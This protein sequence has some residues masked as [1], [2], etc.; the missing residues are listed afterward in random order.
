[1]KTVLILLLSLCLANP[2]SAQEPVSIAKIT[3]HE[4]ADKSTKTSRPFVFQGYSREYDLSRITNE[5]SGN[6][7]LGESIAK[8]V[9]LLDDLYTSEVA[10]VPGN[11]QMKTIIKKPVIYT[12]V[13][14]IEKYMAKAVKKGEISK[15]LAIEEFNRVLDVA[16]SVLSEDTRQFEVEIEALH[17]DSAR[18]DLFTRRV[19]LNY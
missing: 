5:L 6:H 16:L 10:V 3:V 18:I 12:A 17:D 7:F 19:S 9:Y 13:K 1:M 15:E 4:G 2:S 11:P 14:R 8:K